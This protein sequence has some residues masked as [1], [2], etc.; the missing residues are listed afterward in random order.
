MKQTEEVAYQVI[1]AGFG[2]HSTVHCN[3]ADSPALTTA[4]FSDSTKLGIDTSVHQ[5][6]TLASKAA[7]SQ[8]ERDV[9]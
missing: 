8:T 2:L 5:T 7:S 9:I 1:L 3:V 4:L 6:I